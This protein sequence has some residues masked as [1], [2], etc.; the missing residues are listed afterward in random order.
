MNNEC[1]LE[2]YILPNSQ[3]IKSL[4]HLDYFF[5]KNSINEKNIF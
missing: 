3:K 5:E 4:Y 2:K 1:S